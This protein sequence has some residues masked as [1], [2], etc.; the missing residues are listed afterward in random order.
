MKNERGAYITHGLSVSTI[1]HT[2]WAW[3]LR[4]REERTNR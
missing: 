1:T 2:D 4:A 3:L